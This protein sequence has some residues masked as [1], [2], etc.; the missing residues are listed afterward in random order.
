MTSTEPQEPAPAGPSLWWWALV[1]VLLAGVLLLVVQPWSPHET[2]PVLPTDSGTVSI[3]PSPTPPYP[4]TPSPTPTPTPTP[5]GPEVPGEDAVF[6]S[7]TQARLFVRE[8]RLMADVPAAK[9]GVEPRIV[10]G[11]LDWGLP[12]GSSVLPARCTTAVT[13]V[14]EPPTGF[15]ARSWGNDDMQFFQTV[16]RLPDAATARAAFRDLVSTLDGCPRYEQVNPSTDGAS[17]V[18]EPAIEG[19][20][21]YPSVVAQRVQSAEGHATPQYEGHMLV[22]N[23]IVSWTASAAGAPADEDLD[24]P[25]QLATL[26][27]AESLSLMVQDRAQAA[28]A[29]LG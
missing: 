17:W 7:A 26:G 4:P 2:E 23:V 1:V 25:G 27:S 13:V 20:G 3:R 5:T 24:V 22:G 10:S 6:D 28:V 19:Q 29:A 8:K 9:D 12:A 16:T 18:A 11:E 21:V 14:P 15:D